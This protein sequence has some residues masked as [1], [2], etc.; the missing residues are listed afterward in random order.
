[1]TTPLIDLLYLDSHS[2]ENLV[3]ADISTYP[4]GF[5]IMT[6]TIEVTPPSFSPIQVPFVARSIQIY[7]SNSLGVTIGENCPPA[8]LPDGVYKF[9]Y[10]IFPAYK[11]FVN[12]S[13]LRIEKLLEKYDK[14]Y[15]KLDILQCDLTIKSAEKKQLNLIWEYINGAIA[16]ANNCAEKQAMELYNRA[17]DAIDIFSKN[18]KCT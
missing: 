12:K 16:S 14:A 11:Y 3:I 18:C 2:V 10:T 6:P 13:F 4:T 17:S 1:M 5:T 8:P 15:V 7:N 9:K